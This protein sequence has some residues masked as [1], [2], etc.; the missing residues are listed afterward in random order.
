MIQSLSDR[1]REI[2]E[3][4]VNKYLIFD[5]QFYIAPSHELI[6]QFGDTLYAISHTEVDDVDG[7]VYKI[8]TACKPSVKVHRTTTERK[9][10]VLSQQTKFHSAEAIKKSCLIVRTQEDYGNNAIQ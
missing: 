9:E 4:L 5:A 3:I 2:C 7:E 8:Y 10:S 1:G 6:I